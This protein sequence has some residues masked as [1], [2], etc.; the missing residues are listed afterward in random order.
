MSGF[1][2]VGVGETGFKRGHPLGIDALVVQAARRAIA[3]AG[4]DPSQ[5]D[6]I[7]T[8][9]AHPPH[10]EIALGV[11][12]SRRA[13]SAIN[14]LI[15]GAGPVAAII[16]AQL[17]IRAGLATYVLIAYGTQTSKPGGPY[18]YHAADPLKADL[19]MPVGY[20]GQPM[21][22]AAIAQRYRHE[23]GL[24]PEQ[25]GSLA[26]AQREWASRTPGA[27]KPVPIT[28]DEYLAAPYIAEPLRNLD[29]CLISDG[30]AAFVVTSLD[31]ARDLR[32][33]PA[34]IAGVAAG[35]NPWTL[36]EMFTQS[37]RFLDIGPGDA[38]RQAL[39]QAGIRH[40]E[41]DFAEIYDCFTLSIILQLESLGFCQ[42]GE[43]ASFV[44]G[45]RTGP[46]GALPVNTHGGHLSHAYIPGITHVVEA[47]RQIR[48]E[49]GAGQIKDA[50][51]GLVSV[52]GGPDHATLVLT[53]DG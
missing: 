19:E 4:L 45:G 15:P 27:Q 46:G 26:V 17:A 28:L 21:Y 8:P 5:V 50:R 10:D 7:V 49:R 37:P 3:D 32:T 9:D 23:F 43:G 44:A 34:V 12:M 1:A 20:Y 29:C 40:D 42:R 18:A 38:G 31:R 2:I 51:V 30:A 36:R 33:K 53:R 13:F 6:G 14:P 41:V 35:S 16:Q 11:G 22:F 25:L 39:E 48:G 47:V 24:E 52:F